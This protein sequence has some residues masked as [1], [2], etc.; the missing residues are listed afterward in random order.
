MKK[1]FIFIM[2]SSFLFSNNWVRG[3]KNPNGPTGELTVSLNDVSS[4]SG[5]YSAWAVS[6]PLTNSA[7]VYYHNFDKTM[8]VDFHIPLYKL[9]IK[10]GGNKNKGKGRKNPGRKL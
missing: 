4:F 3:L 9:F 8:Q 7:T 2:L 1:L 6:M 5:D 10:K